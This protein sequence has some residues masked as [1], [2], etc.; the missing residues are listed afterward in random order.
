MSSALFT[1]SGLRGVI[2]TTLTPEY[3]ALVAGGFGTQAGGGRVALGRDCRTSSELLRNSVIA[4]LI[5]AGSSVVDLGVCPTPTVGV[6]VREE[7]LA[8]GIMITASH[9]PPD[10]NGLKFVS[11]AGTF[12][13]A[14]QVT[15]LRRLIRGSALRRAA[16]DHLGKVEFLPEAIDR[17]IAQIMKSPLFRRRPRR[18]LRIGIDAC[19]G[20]ASYAAPV[21]VRR[22]GSLPYGLFC[23][24]GSGF[25]RGPEPTPDHL[26]ALGRFVRS[27]RLDLGV[28]FDPD[29][30]RF[31]C[32]DEQGR[33][34]GEEASVM[35]A[36]DFVLRRNP[37]PVV[38]NLSTTR[39]IDDIAARYGVPVYRTRVGEAAVVERMLQV[40]ARVGGEGNG[41][42]TIPE[43]NPARDGLVALAC[44]VQIV[45]DARLPLSEIARTLPG[46]SMVK[47]KVT[48]PRTAWP[49]LRAQLRRE[50]PT[51]LSDHTD[52]L[53]LIG[54]DH[55]L[56]VRPSNTE[57]IVRLIAEASE[58]SVARRLIA[59]A[60]RVI[61]AG[62][63]PGN[64]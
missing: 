10:W 1:I 25:P 29:A 51:G 43:I 22:L 27:N 50:F 64:G 39:G 58:A 13:T 36:C 26:S 2:G 44:L 5:G 53:K 12:L 18:R 59:R 45:S 46:Y 21:L 60:R 7:R 56:H 57:P 9:N 4:G 61:R 6:I 30:D 63:A 35:L 16:W 17:H 8:G 11:P 20:A 28:A 47:D 42:V 23:T 54:R 55:W 49:R 19:H 52:G 41:G 40:K 33:P 3:V 24:P 31:S 48:V 62:L 38:V 32:V 14:K 15:R 34:L 37:G